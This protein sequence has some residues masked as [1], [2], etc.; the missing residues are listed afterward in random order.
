MIIFII[1]YFFIDHWI[2]LSFA[3]MMA[4]EDDTL[5][6]KDTKL[7]PVLTSTCVWAELICY[8]LTTKFFQ[9][10]NSACKKKNNEINHDTEVNLNPQPRVI[11]FNA[12]PTWPLHYIGKL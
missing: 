6:S 12:L 1:H 11:E 2:P 9:K 10:K 4:F 3:N 8:W 5:K 7:A